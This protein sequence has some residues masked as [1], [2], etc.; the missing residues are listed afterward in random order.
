MAV[1]TLAAVVFV[2]ADL[3]IVCIFAAISVLP[4]TGGGVILPVARDAHN[5]FVQP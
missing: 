4:L 3:I 5:C 1:K 2:P